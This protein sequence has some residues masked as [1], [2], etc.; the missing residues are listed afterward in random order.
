MDG[1]VLYAQVERR[2]LDEFDTRVVVSIDGDRVV[3]QMASFVACMTP[4]YSALVVEIATT[5]C[6]ESQV[7]APPLSVKTYPQIE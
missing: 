6:F 2:V 4:M 3:T 1:D 5:D 7:M